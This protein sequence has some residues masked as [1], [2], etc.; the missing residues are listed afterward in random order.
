MKIGIDAREIQNGVI[1]GIGRSLSNFI[2][3]FGE[4]DIRHKLILFSDKA[5]PFVFPENVKPVILDSAH[6]VYWDQV[7]LPNALKKWG[8]D[9]F[10]SPYYKIPIATSVPVMSQI[11]DLMYLVFPDYKNELGMW[12]RIYYALFGRLCA[13]KSVSI[14]TD[15]Q[16]AKDD[17][18]RCWQIN[19]QKIEVI[20]LGLGSRYQ[21]VRDLDC[22]T[23]VRQRL[24]LPD[25][26]ILYLGNFKPH[27]NVTALVDAFAQIAT[28]HQDYHLVLAGACDK[29]VKGLKEYVTA[30]NLT[31]RV[32]FTDMIRESDC[33]EA[34]LSMAEVFVFPTLY[35]GFG[36]P[37]LEAMAC[38][39]PVVASNAT[40]V[41]E[42]VG[43]A[44]ILVNPRDINAMGNAIASLL[45]DPQKRELLSQKGLRRADNFREETTAGK[46]YQ[47]IIGFLENL[48]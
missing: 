47:H 10:Y 34:I 26:F 13:Y 24:N 23:Q 8:I 32:V 5:L 19:P 31:R 14:V 25:K 38:G 11:L 40:A 42:V 39:T 37:P 1:T 48:I 4:N 12:R 35:E 20:H 18:V 3:Y 29:H 27:K 15:S 17:I 21:P 2:H 33:P 6:T 41:P 16:H 36:L 7:R 46:L 9:L 43:D 45:R 28:H 44:G 22:L 30:R